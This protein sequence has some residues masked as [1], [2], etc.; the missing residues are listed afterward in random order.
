MDL[1]VPEP[2]EE[3]SLEDQVKALLG[4]QT[5][6][7]DKKAT[8]A[9]L[10]Q[11]LSQAIASGDIQLLEKALSISDRKIIN[12]TVRNL[13]PVIVTQLIDHL[14]VRL[15]KKPNRASLL[16]EWI[17]AC[18]LHHSGYLLSVFRLVIIGSTINT[19]TWVSLPVTECT[20]RNIS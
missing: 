15:Q 18:L 5:E 7:M 6:T 4:N 10:N 9:S 19:K 2:E 20:P 17:R 1:S 16:I 13:N 3:I 14:V 11:V 12:A 8:Q